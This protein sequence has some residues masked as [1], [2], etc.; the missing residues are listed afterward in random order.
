VKTKQP[1]RFLKDVWT[2]DEQKCKTLLCQL[3]SRPTVI[4]IIDY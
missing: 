3:N 1:I 4:I 2:I